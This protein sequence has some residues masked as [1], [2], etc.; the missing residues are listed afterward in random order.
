MSLLGFL[1]SALVVVRGALSPID[2]AAV[3]GVDAAVVTTAVFLGFLTFLS[4]VVCALVVVR[5]A[6]GPTDAAAVVGVVAA[7]VTIAAFLE[8]FALISLAGGCRGWLAFPGPGAWPSES[9]G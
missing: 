4:L 3:V 7:I 6:Q 5:G 1:V 9:Q 8:I 2:T